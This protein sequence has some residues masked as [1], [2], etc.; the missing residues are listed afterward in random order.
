VSRL[1]STGLLLW[2]SPLIAG[3]YHCLNKYFQ[4]SYSNLSVEEIMY[5]SSITADAAASKSI[6]FPIPGFNGDYLADVDGSIWSSK[7]GRLKRL[8]P[9]VCRNGY[10]MVG[11]HQ[12][13]R[14]SYRY[15]HQLVLETFRSARPFPLAVAAHYPSP[16]KADCSIGNL[17]WTDR[18]TNAAH[19]MADGGPNRRE[20][21]LKLNEDKVREIRRLKI[22]GWTS[23]DL[24]R[25]FGTGL[26]AIRCVLNRTAWGWVI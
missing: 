7:S 25:K 10:L 17:I 4:Q 1:F 3:F 23:A 6:A 8:S 13:G 9:K 16:N 19:W 24:A 18:K 12:N 2:R 14:V 15:V 11:L 26:D 21:R 22:E 5:Y 20:N